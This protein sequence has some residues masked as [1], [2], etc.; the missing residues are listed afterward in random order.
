MRK[1]VK[2][3][4]K[5]G[6]VGGLMS[7]MMVSSV[8]AATQSLNGGKAT[9]SG[10]ENTDGILYSKLIDNVNDGLRYK[11]CVWVRNDMGQ[12]N[13]K[14]RTTTG[15]GKNGQVKVTIAATHKNPLKTEKAGYKE[16]QVVK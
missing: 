10:G 9:W 5:A 14:T 13:Q 12:Y 4:V 16:F 11:A 15:V 7:M 1:T 6:M 3:T 2:K 8:F